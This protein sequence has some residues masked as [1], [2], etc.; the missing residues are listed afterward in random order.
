MEQS[1]M[2]S[3]GA[4]GWLPIPGIKMRSQKT[5]IKNLYH[6]GQWTYPGA[7][8]PSVFISGRN[9]KELTIKGK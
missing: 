5:P 9:A 2:N 4:M 6:A 8:V 1:T 7:G 3:Q